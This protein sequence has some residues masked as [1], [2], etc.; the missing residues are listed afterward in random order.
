[1]IFHQ[2]L[3]DQLEYTHSDEGGGLAWDVQAWVGRDYNRL[4]FKSEGERRGGQIEEGRIELLWSR[5]VEAFWDAQ[6]GLRRDFGHGP[7]RNWLAVG[8]QGIAPYLFDIEA[9]AYLGT[10]GRTALRLSAEY[11]VPITQRTFLTPEVEANLHGKSDR[12]RGVGSGLSDV[13]FGLRL[14]HEFRREF[15]PYVGVVWTRSLGRTADFVRAEG[16][17]VSERQIVAGVRFWF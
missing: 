13:S 3:I 5:P 6:V 1:M 10:G 17:P 8:V 2:V 11:E 15:A 16:A 14:R 9:T 4:F 7:K 12:E